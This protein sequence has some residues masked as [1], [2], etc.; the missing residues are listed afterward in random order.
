MKSVASALVYLLL[1]LS[2]SACDE[3]DIQED[4][5]DFDRTDRT[6]DITFENAEL[7]ALGA[8]QSVIIPLAYLP[9][10]RFLDA[11]ELPSSAFLDPAPAPSSGFMD[12]PIY[13]RNCVG[14]GYARYQFTRASG[15]THRPGDRILL[16]YDAC[17]DA[18]GVE[19]NGRISARYTAVEGLN[20]RFVENDTETC[21]ANLAARISG[22]ETRLDVSADT[23]LFYRRGAL[24]D[25]H[26]ANEVPQ[27]EDGGTQFETQAVH[28]FTE[29]DKV[30][31]VNSVANATGPAS[32][33]GDE[34]Y[35]LVSGSHLR[36]KCQSYRRT[37]ALTMSSYR[38]DVGGM[39]VILSGSVTYEQQ[40]EDDRVHVSGTV[41]SSYRVT[42]NQGATQSVFDF[43]DADIAYIENFVTGATGMRP[44]GMLRSSALFGTVELESILT[45][46]GVAS[47]PLPDKGRL[48][49]NGRGLERLFLDPDENAVT[50]Q[51]DFDGDSNG[52]TFP[53][54][55]DTI[56]TSWLRLLSRDFVEA[57]L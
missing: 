24:I 40:T 46:E 1:L 44:N 39:E 27:G 13:R 15:E 3:L 49:V 8:T 28:T 32:L 34:V 14:G 55:D 9:L 19:R 7:I 36:E 37:L 22:S 53:D 43:Y 48:E 52:D 29:Q 42:V 16:D 11:S 57:S 6:T 47:Q 56:F 10:Q 18:V 4:D 41:N 17:I 20:K 33:G 38:A 35:S 45:L 2:V 23:V 51:V 50:L 5:I 31:I 30:I 25:V 26:E 54:I 21:V 12:G